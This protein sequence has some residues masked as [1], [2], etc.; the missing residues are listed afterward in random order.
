MAEFASRPAFYLSRFDPEVQTFGD[1]EFDSA[2]IESVLFQGDAVITDLYTVISDRLH[3]HIL[4]APHS[5]SLFEESLGAGLV[6][7]R[8]RDSFESFEHMRDKLK[9]LLGY[10]PESSMI[11][12]RLDVAVGQIN[13]LSLW[14]PDVGS[15]F[16]VEVRR[17]LGQPEHPW[18]RIAETPKK[19]HDLWDATSRWR[20]VLLDEAKHRTK[21]LGHTGIKRDQILRLLQD[22]L[23][24]HGTDSRQSGWDLIEAVEQERGVIHQPL[25]AYWQWVSDCYRAN[26]AHCF[27][28]AYS[29]PHF[30][31]E[32]S[33]VSPTE[34]E[35]SFHRVLV[36]IIIPSFEVLRKIKPADI[37]QIRKSIGSAYLSSLQ[38]WRAKP[39][40]ATLST[41]LEL[42]NK[43]ATELCLWARR[44]PSYR[45]ETF[46]L[47]LGLKDAATAEEYG[48]IAKGFLEMT[49]G[50]LGGYAAWQS[51][52]GPL[53]APISALVAGGAFH[54]GQ[55]IADSASKVL[56]HS[57][58]LFLTG[59][60][61]FHSP[62]HRLDLRACE[63]KPP[64]LDLTIG[65]PDSI[66][67]Q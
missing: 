43:Y 50:S 37:L 17:C 53:P 64:A 62:E 18:A 44:D 38:V 56:N 42:L 25:R 29:S 12:P 1:L 5:T 40:E 13:A 45:A 30:R 32:T 55:R 2:L 8:T 20:T 26:H 19:I 21:Q 63:N 35:E 4:N 47:L 52:N 15:G 54:A 65:P 7:V 31:P 10:R 58:D 41:M 16:E 49:S 9:H 28:A 24:G 48:R 23:L 11:A 6:T 51:L 34:S 61:R 66:L 67:P 59:Y 60:I 36:P 27:A 57:L 33:V 39:D 46:A 14:P 22:E 3:R